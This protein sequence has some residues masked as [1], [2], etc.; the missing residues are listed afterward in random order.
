[1]SAGDECVVWALLYAATN[2]SLSHHAHLIAPPPPSL[3]DAVTAM[4]TWCQQSIRG[5][6]PHEPLPDSEPYS[7]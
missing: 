6:Q 1:M 2:P 5:N 4:A 3:R 7:V